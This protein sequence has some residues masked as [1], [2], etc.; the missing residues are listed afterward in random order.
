MLFYSIVMGNVI[1]NPENEE[2]SIKEF[3]KTSKEQFEGKWTI[4]HTNAEL[5]PYFKKDDFHFIK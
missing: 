1:S 3:L 5:V 2:E 4:E